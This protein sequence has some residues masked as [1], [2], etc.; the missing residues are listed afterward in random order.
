MRLRRVLVVLV[1]VLVLAS[2]GSD[3]GDDPVAIE[4]GYTALRAAPD[5][6][7]DA[8]PAKLHYRIEVDGQVIEADGVADMARQQ[9]S[10]ELPIPGQDEAIEMIVEGRT[11]YMQ[12]PEEGR[13]DLGVSTPW[14]SIDTERAGQAVSGITGGLGGTSDPSD[15]LAGLRGVAEGGVRRIG[16]EELRGVETTHFQAEVDLRRALEESGAIADP[17]AFQRFAAQLGGGAATY[18][19]WLDG[20]GLVR[21]LRFGTPVQG[22]EVSVAMELYDFG[23][24][25]V[26]RIPAPEDVTDITDQAIAQAGQAPA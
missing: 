26:A 19:V 11:L 20:D 7:E 6:T 16:T 8:G 13:A 24:A 25:T 9:L 21:K 18:D 1:S 10:L 23:E 2:C 17:E 14:I 12:V 22:S 5:A 15:A 3:G 4:D